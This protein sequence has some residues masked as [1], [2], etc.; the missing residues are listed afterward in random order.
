VREHVRRRLLRSAIC[1][2]LGT[3]IRATRLMHSA[4]TTGEGM[5]MQVSGISRG[6]D[7]PLANSEAKPRRE[8]TSTKCDTRLARR[9]WDCH[10]NE[11]LRDSPA[12]R[13]CSGVTR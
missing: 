7:S 3:A 1:G 5:T 10:F 4:Y 6:W 9:W 13:L 12:I 8:S 11:W 2:A